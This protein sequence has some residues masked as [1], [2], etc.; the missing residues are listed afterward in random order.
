[1]NTDDF[2]S[3]QIID[4]KKYLS[5]IIKDAHNNSRHQKCLICEKEGGFCNSHTIPQFCLKN[6]AWDGKLNS[7]NTLVDTAL[8][9]CDSGVNSAGTFHIICRQCDGTV[10]QDYENPNSYESDITPK[11]LNQIVLKNSLRDIYKHETELEILDILLEF[12]RHNNPIGAII[13]GAMFEAQKIARKVDIQEC[14]TIFNRAKDNLF[15]KKE[16]LKVISYDKLDYVVPIAYQGMVALITGVNSEIIND[17]FN[18]NKDYE[19]EYL[20]L[21]ILPLKKSSIVVLFHDDAYKRHSKF[22]EYMKHSSTAERLN[23]VNRIVFLYT[24]DYYLSKNLSMEVVDQ[25]KTPAKIMQDYVSMNPKRSQ[26]NAVKDFDLRRD[27]GL[28]NILLKEYAVT[29]E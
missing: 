23:I 15:S 8:L 25:L 4:F 14:Y 26:K 13:Y 3:E 22:D 6:I 21:A 28:P 29:P 24:E 19:V 5:K 27:T 12:A 16:W 20:Q 2:S 10:F 17:Q 18:Y 11:M 7:F 1:M 9:P